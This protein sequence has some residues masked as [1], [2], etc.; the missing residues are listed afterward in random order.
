MKI[1]FLSLLLAFIICTSYA[2][3]GN[4]RTY[5]VNSTATRPEIDSVKLQIDGNNAYYQKTVKVDSGIKVSMIYLRA[6]Q[7]MA[8]KNFQENCGYEQEGKQIFTTSQ[9]LNINPVTTGND[10]D[11]VEVYTVQFAITIDMKNGRYRYTVH[12][13]VFFRPTETGNMRLTLFDMHQ[14][15]TGES[16]SVSKDARKVIAS[17]ERYLSTLTAELYEGIEHKSAIYQPKF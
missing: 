14:K 4:V 17:F 9:D 16:R 3:N 8:A 6:L 5:Q 2:Q 1:C 7:F 13:V 11:N 15:A 10:L 12:N